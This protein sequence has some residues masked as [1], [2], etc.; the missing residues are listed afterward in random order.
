MQET[1]CKCCGTQSAVPPEALEVWER[2]PSQIEIT[3]EMRQRLPEEVIRMLQEQPPAAE[4]PPLRVGFCNMCGHAGCDGIAPCKVPLEH[5]DRLRQHET[6][7]KARAE[8]HDLAER[9]SRGEPGDTG[10]G[11]QSPTEWA[12]V[13]DGYWRKEIETD[14]GRMVAEVIK[15]RHMPG[16]VARVYPVEQPKPLTVGNVTVSTGP[17]ETFLYEFESVEEAQEQCAFICKQL[18]GHG[19]VAWDVTIGYGNLVDDAD[20]LRETAG[21]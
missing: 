16:Y 11:V 14:I 15:S 21:S 7:D 6:A 3:E 19:P 18:A 4:F 9:W 1:L 5:W 20:D 2:V 12:Q 10:A 17:G 13:T 8:A